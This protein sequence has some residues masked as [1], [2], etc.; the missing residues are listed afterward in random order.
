MYQ[1]LAALLFASF[2][3]GLVNCMF[4]SASDDSLGQCGAQSDC[5]CDLHC[6]CHASAVP[7]SYGHECLPGFAG[8]SI[9][10]SAFLLKLPL[11]AA[12]IFNPHILMKPSVGVKY[13]VRFRV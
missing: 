13:L 6:G 10:P 4:A 1:P 12:S 5:H 7:S 9:T 8:Y 11:F 2:V 3:F